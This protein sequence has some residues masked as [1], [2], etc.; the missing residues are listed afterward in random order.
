MEKK[1]SVIIPTLFRCPNIMNQLLGSLY[2]D[3]A[4]SEVIIIDNTVFVDYTPQMEFHSKTKMYSAGENLYV[5]PSWNYGVELAKEDYIAILN[6]DITIPEG[7]LT[8]L[9]KVD[10]KSMGMIGACHPMIQQVDNPQRFS[11]EQAELV[12]IRERIWAY[13]IFMAMH[14]D[15]YTPIPDEIK[16]WCGDDIL[17][18]RNRLA[19]RQ[20]YTLVAPIQTKMSTTS[21]DKQFDDIKN[22]DIIL[23]EQYKKEHGI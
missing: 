4:V 12:P 22:N 8:S 23:Y 20:N 5:N 13:G 21:D 14:K 9:S 10:L 1:F 17:F 15:N 3:D 11:I 19:G 18:H 6:D 16:V 2:I 7:M